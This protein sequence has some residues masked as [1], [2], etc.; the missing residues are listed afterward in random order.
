M[1]KNILIVMPGHIV[2][3]GIER[4]VLDVLSHIDR[5]TFSIDI[6][7]AGIVYS[8]DFAAKFRQLGCNLLIQNIKFNNKHRRWL[9]KLISLN[10]VLEKKNYDIVDVNTGS[11]LLASCVVTACKWNKI[12]KLAIHSHSNQPI[13]NK[14]KE[15]IFKLLRKYI[16]KNTDYKIA[17]SRTA[18]ASMF[19]EAEADNSVIAKNGIETKKFKF[20]NNIRFEYRN[21]LGIDDNFVIGHAGRFGK[22]KNHKFLI[23]IFRSIAAVDTTAR[24]L[25]IGAGE[26]EDEIREMVNKNNLTDKVIFAGETDKVADYMCAMD[27]FVLPSLF[28]GF[29]IVSMEA[30]A[31]GLPC[32][33]SDSITS[34]I[35][36]TD[37]V[38]FLPLENGAEY[39]A[40]IILSYSGRSIDRE[41][42][43]ENVYNSGY[44][45]SNA[46]DIIY[47]LYSA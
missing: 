23:E 5:S 41:N 21:R 16:S 47:K 45:I 43:W 36:L 7:A 2:T 14:I 32:V 37:A 28:E 9:K 46:A 6:F 12:G 30:Q 13:D 18:A 27:I 17:C 22:E 11:L 38:E 31:T 4:Y 25:L 20:D 29:P 10:N 8:E 42:A 33:C 19:G 40:K 24:L 3:S 15:T 26:L 44:D 39:W 1:K 35:K 34:E